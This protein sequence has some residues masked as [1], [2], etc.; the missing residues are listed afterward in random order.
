MQHLQTSA[1]HRL[2]AMELESEEISENYLVRPLAEMNEVDYQRDRDL[3]Y[4]LAGQVVRH[5]RG[6]LSESETRNV[7]QFHQRTLVERVTAQ[8]RS[9]YEAMAA[10]YD[11]QVNSGFVALPALNFVAAEETPEISARRWMIGAGSAG[12][13]STD[14]QSVCTRVSDSIPIRSVG[15]RSYWK[16]TWMFKSG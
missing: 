14:L 2:A 4:K 16:T 3:L 13:Y 15:S 12:W 11:V 8:M 7:L 10:A 9:R 5:L 6:Y 1:K